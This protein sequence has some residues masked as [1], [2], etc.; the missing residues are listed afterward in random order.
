MVRQICIIDC[1]SWEQ[2]AGIVL[3]TGTHF[4]LGKA[5]VSKEKEGFIF[6]PHHPGADR[7]SL[8]FT[9]CVC[10]GL[11]DTIQATWLFCFFHLLQGMD[12]CSCPHAGDGWEH[13]SVGHAGTT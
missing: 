11:E 1:L 8:V 13:L 9:A 5:M 12:F 3:Q 6:I 4:L 2:Q 7:Q 10:N